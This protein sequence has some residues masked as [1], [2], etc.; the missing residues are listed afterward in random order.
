MQWMLYGATGYTGRLV[1]EE[2]LKHGHKPLIAGRNPDKLQALANLYDLDFVAFTLDDVATVTEAISNVDVVYH[3][4][5]PFIETS[6]V[7]IRAC[8]ATKTHY[9][10][11]T[12]ELPVFEKTFSYDDAARKNGIA[13][14]SGAGFDVVPTDCLVAHVAEQVPAATH[15]EIGLNAFSGT[16]AGT[17]KSMFGMLDMS[18]AIRREGV[19]VNK[20]PGSISKM[21]PLSSG[22]QRGIAIPWGDLSTAYHSTGIPNIT[23][24]MVM[25]TAALMLTR[26]SVLFLPLMKLGFVQDQLRG[27]MDSTLKG[28]DKQTR[29]T[30]RTFIWAKAT[31]AHGFSAESWLETV[32]VYRYTAEIAIHA[33]EQIFDKHPIGALSP[34]QAFGK[35]F[36]LLVEGTRRL[37]SL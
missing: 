31:D 25:P 2:A 1:I 20:M 13:L 7:M 35:D 18:G 9:L 28:P 3:A 11:I 17:A 33:V 36:A 10:D 26:F 4:A 37:D 5:G 32:E 21:I 27:F 15:L 16:S 30:Q 29:D 23:A 19:L 14:V 24:Y 6:D 22:K 34:A 12:G 8:L